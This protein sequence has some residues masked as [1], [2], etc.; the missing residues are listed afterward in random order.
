MYAAIAPYYDVTH[1]QLTDDL[2]LVLALAHQAGGEILE[3]GCGTGR[4]LLPLVRAGY[5]VTGLDSSREMLVLAR[6]KLA[7]EPAEIRGRARLLEGDMTDLSGCGRD[8]ALVI[9]PYNTFMH[10]SPTQAEQTLRQAR[11]CLKEKGLL[12]VD[13]IN[14]YAVAQT[15]NDHILTLEHI[16][17]DPVSG[18]DVLQF[19]RNHLD[20]SNQILHITWIYDTSP[21]G[22]GDIHRTIVPTAYH[23][24]YPHQLEILL[25][26][27][28][29]RVTNWYGQYNQ[30]PFS[31]D[32]DRLLI[33][34]SPSQ[35]N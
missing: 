13:L 9:I 12:F 17:T 2:G 21:V 35:S 6:Q 3:L 8:F 20:D 14:P 10:L 30:T 27:T 16:F 7:E 4:L 34:A 24:Y 18:R 29:W 26:D 32:S 1:A 5:R 23:Y 31:E 11:L 22:G 25:T 28:G 19:A 15:P 33:L